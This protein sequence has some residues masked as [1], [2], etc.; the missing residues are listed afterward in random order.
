MEETIS[1]NHIQSCD[2]EALRQDVSVR[3]WNK[4]YELPHLIYF[5]W[6]EWVLCE[7]NAVLV[8]GSDSDGSNSEGD[9]LDAS[10]RVVR[11]CQ[12]VLTEDMIKF[13]LRLRI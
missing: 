8:L 1:K 3:M 10:I 7:V 4:M 2:E 12:E 5:K 6:T 11:E 9:T 13:L